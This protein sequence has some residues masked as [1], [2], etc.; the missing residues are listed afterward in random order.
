MLKCSFSMVISVVLPLFDF[1]I[2]PGAWRLSY[3]YMLHNELIQ[4]VHMLL[5]TYFL[6][7]C[8]K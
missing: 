4:V 6:L 7:Y 2:F 3:F 8:E 1:N 5:S